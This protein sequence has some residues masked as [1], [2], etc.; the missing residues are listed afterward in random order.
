MSQPTAP[1]PVLLTTDG[2]VATVTLNRPEGMNALTVAAKTALL[3]VLRR[4]HDDYGPV[5]LAVTENGAAF[6]DEVDAD[7]RVRDADRVR[8]LEAHVRACGRA[9]EA[10]VPRRGYFAWSLLDNFEWSWGYSK[11]FGITY[12]D[13]ATQR[14]V[15]KDSARWYAEVIRRNGPPP[16]EGAG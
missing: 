16:E 9:I 12:V 11:R 15:L 3:E 8:Y 1:E 13:Y 6:V 2:A 10:G 4:V 7:G 5:P 14:R